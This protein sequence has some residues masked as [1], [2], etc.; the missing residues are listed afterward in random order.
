MRIRRINLFGGPGCGKSTTAYALTAYLKQNGVNADLCT[1]YVKE[2]VY[3][4][5]PVQGFDQ[6]YLF[7]KQLHKEDVLLRGGVDVIVTD[8]PL[9]MNYGYGVLQ[10]RDGHSPLIEIEQ[11]FEAQYP[12]VDILLERGNLPYEGSGRFENKDQALET[13]KYIHNLL[14]GRGTKPFYYFLGTRT[15]DISAFVLK[16]LRTQA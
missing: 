7:A 14:L 11:E 3:L 1:E 2:W 4:N 5:R 12:S 15:A 9:F 16:T 6:V 8:S 10:K 13:D